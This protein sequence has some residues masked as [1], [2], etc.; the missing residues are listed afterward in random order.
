MNTNIDKLTNKFKD[1]DNLVRFLNKFSKE[2]NFN[3][4]FTT[5]AE[6]KNNNQ[7]I[8]N[9]IING[10]VTENNILININS[11]KL[12]NIIIGHEIMHLFEHTTDYQILQNEVFKYA[13]AK[14]DFD[15]FKV[16]LTETYKNVKDVNID[17]ELTSELIGK[18]LF[19]DTT[20]VQNLSKHKNIFLK[21][22]NAIK[23]LYK[24]ATV[25]SKEARQLEKIKRTFEKI[26]QNNKAKTS[27]ETQF[28]LSKNTLKEV[29]DVVT[30]TKTEAEKNDTQFVKL[31]D[32]TIKVL[33]NNGIP[34][35][36]MLERVS[37]VRENILSEQQARKLGFSIKGKHYHGL[38][39]KTYLN[40]IDSMDNPI[41]VYQYTAK[42]NYNENNFIVV[43][44]VKINNTNFIVPVEVNKRGQ[45]NLVEIN[46]NRIKSVYSKNS[47]NY[48]T[49]MLKQGKI[50][51]IFTQSTSEQTSLTTNNVSHYNKNVKYNTSNK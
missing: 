33:I 9:R 27:T 29:A 1:F 12:L 6:L 22:F 3:Y 28:S 43:T 45:Y 24:M 35:L 15:K 38:G 47:N 26:Y 18:Y 51:E 31:K 17:N 36:P 14:G 23:H 37:H 10:L 5:I 2:T 25:G 20:F 48:I 41:A 21:I 34:D 30:Q 11:H 16:E 50:K 49:I 44:P 42:G 8:N 13:K 4:Y 40:I 32:K 46:Y 39:V 7:A 19:C